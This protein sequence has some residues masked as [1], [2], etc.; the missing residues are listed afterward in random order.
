MLPRGQRGRSG[1]HGWRRKHAAPSHAPVICP[2][3]CCGVLRQGGGAPLVAHMLPVDSRGFKGHTC[4]LLVA[5]E[6]AWW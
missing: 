6:G 4:Q 1:R 2:C 5:N 3:I